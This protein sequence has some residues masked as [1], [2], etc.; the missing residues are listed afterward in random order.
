MAKYEKK[1]RNAGEEDADPQQANTVPT[2]CVH[3]NWVPTCRCILGGCR[4]CGGGC[5]HHSGGGG[6]GRDHEE[7]RGVGCDPLGQVAGVEVAQVAP[8]PDVAHVAARA[9]YAGDVLEGEA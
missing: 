2:S 3:K 8:R 1:I 6:G 7:R 9:A 4:H 5:S